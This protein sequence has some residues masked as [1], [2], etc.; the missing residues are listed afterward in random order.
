MLLHM[1]S[2]YSDQTVQIDAQV[3]LSLL[4]IYDLSPDMTKTT[5]CVWAQSDQSLRCALNG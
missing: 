5:K 2:K 1:I 4:G 3:D